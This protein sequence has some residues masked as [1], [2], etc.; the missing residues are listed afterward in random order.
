[1]NSEVILSGFDNF[2]V[3]VVSQV[4]LAM[5]LVVLTSSL[6]SQVPKFHLNFLSLSLNF[7]E[8]Q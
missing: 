5:R 2:E 3:I 6:A 4:G 7:K 1:L 8:F